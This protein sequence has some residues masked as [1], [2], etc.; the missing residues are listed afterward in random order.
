VVVRCVLF[1]IKS[2]SLLEGC[3]KSYL[4]SRNNQILSSIDFVLTK[5][6]IISHFIYLTTL[7]IKVRD[8]RR[9]TVDRG[10]AGTS[11][12]NRS[13]NDGRMSSNRWQAPQ[14]P[15]HQNNNR[16]YYGSGST[17]SSGNK[18]TRDDAAD[19]NEYADEPKTK[20]SRFQDNSDDE[21]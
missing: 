12:G 13:N 2:V 6:K 7:F 14:R 8:D 3:E 5:R 20:N 11:R 21:A 9:G 17:D 16:N 1:C 18:R 4:F 19:S 10:R 15:Y